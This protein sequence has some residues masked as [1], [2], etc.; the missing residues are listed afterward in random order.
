MT[1]LP[2]RSGL[3]VAEGTSEAPLADVVESLFLDRGASIV[4]SRPD[5]T[6]LG[7]VPKD[8][9]SRSTAGGRL[10]RDPPDVVVVHRDADNAGH[11]E[12]LDEIRTALEGSLP[13]SALVPVIPIRMTEAWLLL[14]EPAIRHVAGNP[15][16]RAPLPLPK[17]REVERAADPKQILAECLL[18]AANVSGRKRQQLASRFP[19]N[20]RQLLERLDLCGPVRELRAWREMVAAIDSVVNGWNGVDQAGRSRIADG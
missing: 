20:R 6:R 18:A 1:D 2:I 13:E 5:F 14:D 3:F 4:L 8:V 19:Q 7:N 17:R 11:D 10:R 16:G 15:R 9:R 12:R